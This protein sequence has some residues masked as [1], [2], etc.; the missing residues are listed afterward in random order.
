MKPVVLIV[1]DGWGI[2]PP[3]RGNALSLAR[4]PNYSHLWYSFPHTTLAA[5][6][7][8]VGLPRGE[9]G[10]TETGH[11]NLGAGRIVY[12]DLPRINMAIADGSF[13]KNS[14]FLQAIDHAK[15]N[16]AKL[17]LLGL[18]GTGG[19][20]SNIEHL[21]ALLHCC[22]EQQ[23]ANVFLH[24]ITDGRDSPPTSARIYIEQIN[25]ELKTIGLGKI[26]SIMGRYYAMD[27]DLR[28]DRTEKA[29]RALIQGQGRIAASC[30]EAIESSYAQGQTDEFIEPTII[31]DGESPMALVQSQDSVIFFNFR[32]DRTRQLTKAFVLEDFSKE[33]ARSAGFDPYAIDYY[34]KHVAY[35]IA[36]SEPFNRGPKV[37]NLF[38]ATMTEYERG[39]PVD[40][41]AYPPETISFP[42]GK[43]LANHEFHQLRCTET[44]K[45]RFVTYYFN[46]Q[47]EEPFPLE[48]RLIVPSPKVPTYDL[49]PEM[50]ALELTTAI[51]DQIKRQFY[52]FILINFPNVDMVGHT[53]VIDA[54][55]IACET[56]DSC[57]GRIIPEIISQQ[58]YCIITADHGNVEEMLSPTTGEIDTE[59]S[60]YPVPFILIGKEFE[61]KA[62]E[63]KSG[64]LA[65]VAPTILSLYGIEKPQSMTG[66]NLLQ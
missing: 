3:S 46:G 27:R 22:K 44:E 57:L 62:Q 11:L 47:R 12:Q 55:V 50:S 35:H 28:W 58:G 37:S 43:T 34:K 15:K 64:I 5:S 13:F 51:I 2:A 52:Q 30:E 25:Q 60:T 54:A 53:G 18:I 8:A 41:V 19:V 33:A 56:I 9:R 45:E 65:D 48:D 40:A 26:A 6:G 23:F 66:R 49:K 17:H 20:H 59:H 21:Y 36:I 10:N 63:L 24:L 29:Y 31:K 14:A 7:E 61:G 42:L 16:K 1:L 4:L 38:F 32:I 39:L